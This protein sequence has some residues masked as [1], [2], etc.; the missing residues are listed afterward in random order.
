MVLTVNASGRLSR[1][2]KAVQ[3]IAALASHT[4]GK[5][6]TPPKLIVLHT[7]FGGTASASADWVRRPQ[8]SGQS[9]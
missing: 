1:D 9:A 5:I 8:N 2:G 3:M 6:A 4:G 7:T